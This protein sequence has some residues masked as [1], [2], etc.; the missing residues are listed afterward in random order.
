MGDRA[1]RAYYADVNRNDFA[2]DD[3]FML[4]RV[5]KGLAVGYSFDQCFAHWLQDL[6]DALECSEA[7][8]VTQEPERYLSPQNP[9]KTQTAETQTAETQTQGT[10]V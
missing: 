5:K 10:S 8:P 2:S 6:A 9:V 7:G 1:Y 3:E 4:A